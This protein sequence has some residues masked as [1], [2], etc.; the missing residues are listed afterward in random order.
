MR[1]C[2]QNIHLLF[3]NHMTDQYNDTTKIIWQ[4]PTLI[5]NH[6]IITEFQS[7]HHCLC[8]NSAPYPLPVTPSCW[9]ASWTWWR[10]QD[11]HLQC[12]GGARKPTARSST[13]GSD[14]TV[15]LKSWRKAPLVRNQGS[16][17]LQRKKMQHQVGYYIYRVC[18][19]LHIL[20][21]KH[22]SGKL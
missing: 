2:L 12:C 16:R 7:I 4:M 1:M 20:I 18:R 8:V 9:T 13:T 3:H 15:T 10:K 14:D 6:T 17:A 5:L 11:A 21:L 19:I 22:C